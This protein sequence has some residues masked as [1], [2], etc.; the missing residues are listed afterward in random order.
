M[1]NIYESK[2]YE[3]FV[4]NEISN[5]IA[6]RTGCTKKMAKTLFFNAIAYNTVVEEIIDKAM[7]LLE[8]QDKDVP[9]EIERESA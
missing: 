4:L 2:E 6:N 3:K 9:L 8:S 1:R 5:T 7:W